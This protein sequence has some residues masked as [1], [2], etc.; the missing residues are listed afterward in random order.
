MPPSPDVVPDDLIL[1]AVERSERHRSRQIVSRSD[2]HDHLSV[3]SRSGEVRRIKA[4]ITALT[5][6]DYLQQARAHSIDYWTLTPKGRRRLK[7][8]NVESLLPESPQ[9]QEWRK[10]TTLSAQEI[11]RMRESLRTTLA[12]A[13]ERIDSDASSDVW[14]ELSERLR[15]DAWLLGSSTHCLRE[16]AEP[17]D[18]LADV[19]DHTDPS[20]ADLSREKKARRRS[21]RHGRR[22]VLLWKGAES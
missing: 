8:A 16:W 2:I 4:R 10:A 7:R 6:E 14:F 22:N 13:T 20:D 17:S 19:D 5:E 11:E 18:D 15:R 21:R 3:P 12:E 1:A 9:H